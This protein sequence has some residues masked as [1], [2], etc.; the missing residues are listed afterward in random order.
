MGPFVRFFA[1]CSVWHSAKRASLSSARATTLGKEAISVPRHCFSAE[2][3]DSDTRQSTSL[4]SDQYTPFLFV[5]HITSKQTKDITY[6]SH[7]S[8][9]YITDIIID[10]NI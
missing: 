9:I 8:H 10:I 3:Y 4:Q 7:I 2:C 6:T 5:F 1:E